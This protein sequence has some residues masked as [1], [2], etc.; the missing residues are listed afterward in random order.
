[1]RIVH[2]LVVEAEQRGYEV[3]NSESRDRRERARRSREAVT[4]LVI[5]IRGHR[6]QLSVSEEKVLLRGDWE[7][8]RRAS[9]A[10]RNQLY[11]YVRPE[12]VKPYD[13]EATGILS[14][15]LIISGPVRE[16]RPASWRDR[17]SWTLEDKLPELLYEQELCAVEDDEREAEERR[18]QEERRRRWE[19]MMEVARER[20]REAYRAKVL[21]EQAAAWREARLL[22]EY[23]I[24]LKEAHSESVDSAAWIDWITGFI[25]RLDPLTSPPAMPD[26]PEPS[27]EELRAVLLQGVSP[28]GPE[29]WYVA[30][31]VLASRHGEPL[32]N[33]GAPAPKRLYSSRRC[34]PQGSL[35]TGLGDG[36]GSAGGESG[37]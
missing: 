30:E 20:Y 15:G 24:D 26:M 8:R 36:S 25:E 5:A 32:G 22:S 11:T 37:P 21:R 18:Q 29:R 35:G 6:Y 13:S 16:G 27:H 4:H 3:S 10:Y 9:E 28:Y 33:G 14:I 12:R 23:L 17:K 31:S 34:H 19:Q 2:A 1:M 7:E